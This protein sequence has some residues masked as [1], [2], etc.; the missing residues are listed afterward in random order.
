MKRNIKGQFLRRTT[1]EIYE[2]F[3][4]WY[5]QKGY[6][7][8]HLAG[9]D[10]KLHRYIWEKVHGPIPKG[11]QLHHIDENKSSYHI[12]NLVLV[13]QSDHLKIHSR[14]VKED[15]EWISKPCNR[16]GEILPLDK[17]YKRKGFTPSAL[18]KKCHCEKTREWALNNTEKRR[19]IG[20]RFYHLHKEVMPNDPM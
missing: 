19:E 5:D 18:C 15:G 9:K 10:I 8:I 1:G 7:C 12:E 11:Y 20:R 16:C 14:W 2:G 3:P 4:I 6:A 13:T 17:F